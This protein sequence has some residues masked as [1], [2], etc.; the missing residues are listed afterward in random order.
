M[1]HE[2]DTQ[3]LSDET[4]RL[5]AS[6][7]DRAREL[8]D[9]R[10]ELDRRDVLI[11][12]LTARWE[13]L[14]GG[15]FAPAAQTSEAG[16]SAA[17]ALVQQRDT[18]VARA[19][20][21]EAAA[22]DARFRLDE[23]AGHWVDME[24]RAMELSAHEGALRG[25]RSR[26][27]EAED[28]RDQASARLLLTEHDLQDAQEQVAQGRRQYLELTERAEVEALRSHTASDEATR[29]RAELTGTR[30]RAEE[31]ERAFQA[32]AAANRQ[33][34][35]AAADS[36]ARLSLALAE[37]DAARTALENLRA[38]RDA[39]RAEAGE[40]RAQ[41]SGLHEQLSVAEAEAISL[42]ASVPPEPPSDPRAS[43][44]ED[45]LRET[46]HDLYGL[47]TWLTGGGESPA[48]ARTTSFELE[49]PL[50]VSSL[51]PRE[52]ETQ[53]GVPLH[54]EAIAAVEA[55]AVEALEA[56]L[57]NKDEQLRTLEARLEDLL[58]RQPPA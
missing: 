47:A 58:R 25:L 55:M 33:A 12:D 46:R 37:R 14:G 53:P 35:I 29:L 26:L 36:H 43:E 5:E 44:L 54:V 19:L 15:S 4:G 32:N 1:P 10:A 23:L 16:A 27:A 7:R 24:A 8:L 20:D 30:H 21:A 2:E 18:A 40:L 52:D 51:P 17:A 22:L 42:R 50:G 6:L 57:A 49:A 9:L 39:A 28:A 3:Q 45:A 38:D 13:R 34:T 31:A 48:L 56:Q 11:R 41:V